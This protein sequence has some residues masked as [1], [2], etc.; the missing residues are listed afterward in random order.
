[1]GICPPGKSAR[2]LPQWPIWVQNRQA[3]RNSP[4]VLQHE[5]D[6]GRLRSFRQPVLLVKGTGSARFN[7]QII[8]ALDSLL[9]NAQVVEM[10]AGHS[11]HIVS[12]DQFLERLASFQAEAARRAA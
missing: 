6:I 7:H 3:L 11:P 12:M 2:E 9:P 8:D 10:P 1:M 4:A 5:D